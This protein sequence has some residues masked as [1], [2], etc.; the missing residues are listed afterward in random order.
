VTAPPPACSERISP[1]APTPVRRWQSDRARSG[2]TAPKDPSSSRTRKSFPRPCSF[3]RRIWP[4]G[5]T[6]GRPRPN[7]FSLYDTT[8][9]AGSIDLERLHRLG[10]YPGAIWAR[11]DERDLNI[12]GLTRAFVTVRDGYAGAARAGAGL[13]VIIT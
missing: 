6:A 5:P 2:A 12:E 9:F 3:K 13:L 7:E 8:T 4:H 10:A 1:S 11:E